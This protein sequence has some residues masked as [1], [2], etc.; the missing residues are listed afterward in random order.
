MHKKLALACMALAAVAA[1]AAP[2]ASS[3]ASAKICETSGETCT[4]IAV[5]SKIRDHIVPGTLVNVFT[6]SGTITCSE[7][8]TT[9]VVTKNEEAVS[10][11]TIE[12]AS[13]TGT[14]EG[15]KC[16]GPFGNFQW[17][18][19]VG[20][21]VPY[22]LKNIAGEAM[23]TQIRGNSCTNA[24]RSLTF[25][26]DLEGGVSC[27]YSRSVESGPLKGKYTTDTAPENSDLVVHIPRSATGSKFTKEEGGILCPA[28]LELELSLTFETDVVGTSPLYIK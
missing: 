19:N 21:G 10:E 2:A 22:C 9:G 3:A 5:G 7:A 24:A 13:I 28:S 6:P 20:N 14:G 11:A 27:K 25:V 18:T 17:T 8:L 1:L 16:T 23:E 4:A 15:G 26:W 12:T